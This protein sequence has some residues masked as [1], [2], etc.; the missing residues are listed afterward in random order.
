MK[1]KTKGPLSTL[2]SRAIHAH[3]TSP[4]ST[5]F[6]AIRD[7]ITSS[8]SSRDLENQRKRKEAS[9]WPRAR[10]L[11]T[12]AFLCTR[13]PPPPSA[14]PAP[15]RGSESELSFTSK[16]HRSGSWSRFLVQLSSRSQD[17]AGQLQVRRTLTLPF[18][19][20]PRSFNLPFECKPGR[21]L[22][23]LIMAQLRSKRP[24]AH[25]KA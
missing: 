12:P 23:H 13:P 21:S 10:A 25:P 24:H 2:T 11:N 17:R 15:R 9:Y 4:R 5:G 14:S 19:P 1:E 7:C 20:Q 8:S 16:S 22:T 6:C 18:S 3:P